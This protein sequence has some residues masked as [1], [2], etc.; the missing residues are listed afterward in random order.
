MSNNI[1]N[2]PE[3]IIQLAEKLRQSRRVD[4]PIA[5]GALLDDSPVPYLL[6]PGRYWLA[7]HGT[8]RLMG[9]Q[10]NLE[11]RLIAHSPIIVTRILRDIDSGHEHWELAWLRHG[12]WQYHV[13]PRDVCSDSRRIVQL[14]ALGCPVTS[15]TARELVTYLSEFEACN[16]GL[17]PVES[18]SHH[19]GWQSQGS[20]PIGYL[21]GREW[22]PAREGVYVAYRG[23]D[24]GD[25]QLAD[26]YH[27]AGSIDAWLE[28]LAP[29]MAYDRARL[30]FYLPFVA[31]MLSILGCPNFIVDFSGRTSIGKSTLLRIAASVAGCPDETQPD[32]IIHS[33]DVT[34]VFAERT[35]ATISH[36]PLILDDTKR[37]KNQQ[38]ISEILYMIANGRGRGRGNPR[39]IQRTGAWRTVLISSGEAPAVSYSH[40]GGTRGRVLSVRG[41]PFGPASEQTRRMIDRLSIALRQHYGHGLPLWVRWLIE[42]R[43]QWDEWREAY[44]RTIAAYAEA[45][46]DGVGARLAQYAAAIECVAALVHVAFAESGHELPWDY[47]PPLAKLWDGIVKEASDPLG[48]EEAL[49][50]VWAWAVANANCF[51]GRGA[52]PPLNGWYGKW[53]DKPSWEYIAFDPSKLRKFLTE[54]GYSPDEI[55]GAW[56]ERG[57]IDVPEGQRGYQKK[58]KLNGHSTWMVVVLRSAIDAI[59]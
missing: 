4:D 28:A 58:V 42:H 5:L 31:P 50:M 59:E 34:R 16:I 15:S 23:R 39:G 40:D 22:I 3:N 32:S 29:A 18:V 38:I 26:G 14:S 24:E 2:I 10:D 20:E 25:E 55:L 37:A 27:V 17:M 1:T 30:A 6:C 12:E 33:W 35:S 13:V 49:R 48:E 41:L 46:S 11:H 44:H 43:E 53:E 8:Y 45:A 19:L 52:H 36:L 51:A 56:R 7:E 57:W 9:S 21:Y 47:D 54:Q